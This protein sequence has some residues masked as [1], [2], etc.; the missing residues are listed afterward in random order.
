MTNK[1]PACDSVCEFMT[2]AHGRTAC[3]ECWHIIEEHELKETAV[4]EAVYHCPYCESNKLLIEKLRNQLR[5]LRTDHGF[6]VSSITE[7]EH[8][9]K[10]KAAVAAERMKGWQVLEDMFCSADEL[11]ERID[12]AGQN[13][14]QNTCNFKFKE[15]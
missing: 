10:L 7:L 5:W 14:E 8:Q 13:S 12:R 11:Q 15:P 4:A 1:C 6:A 2:T 3:P 9:A